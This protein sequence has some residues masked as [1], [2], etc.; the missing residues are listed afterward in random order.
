MASVIRYFQVS[1]IYDDYFIKF[2]R[3]RIDKL[4]VML[5]KP[6]SSWSQSATAATMLSALNG[7]VNAMRMLTAAK[8][9]NS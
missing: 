3:R 5:G 7:Q 9:I 8:N 2:E 4:I 6:H 1:A